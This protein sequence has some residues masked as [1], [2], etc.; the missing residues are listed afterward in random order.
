M[1]PFLDCEHQPKLVKNTGELREYLHHFSS[2]GLRNHARSMALFVKQSYR[3]VMARIQSDHF[4][5][6]SI[7]RENVQFFQLSLTDVNTGLF[8]YSPGGSGH[9]HAHIISSAPTRSAK[10][11]DRCSSPESVKLFYGQISRSR[12]WPTP[13]STCVCSSYIC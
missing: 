3:P 12:I 7:C 1:V 8:P 11:S 13:L 6:T 4:S 2:H 10:C 9:S 5:T